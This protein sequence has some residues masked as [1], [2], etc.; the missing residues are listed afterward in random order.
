M[1]QVT[2]EQAYQ[3]ALDHLLENL[4]TNL[5]PRMQASPLTDAAGYTR[6]LE[7]AYRQMWRQWCV[8][9]SV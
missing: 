9:N 3:D 2:V 4:R 7:A 1:A 6:D 8:V 5:R